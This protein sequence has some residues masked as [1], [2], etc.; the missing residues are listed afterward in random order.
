MAILRTWLIE[1]IRLD[2]GA[3]GHRQTVME[4]D[5]T[6]GDWIRPDGRMEPGGTTMW[7]SVMTALQNLNGKDRR[8]IINPVALMDF[9]NNKA[10]A[11]NRRKRGTMDRTKPNE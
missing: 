8:W 5:E 9:C 4:F 3:I 10:L 2:S 11:R 6:T 7:D 1:E